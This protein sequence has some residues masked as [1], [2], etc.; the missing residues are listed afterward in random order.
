MN[1][2]LLDTDLLI[3]YLR[4]HAQ[5][6]EYLEKLENPLAVSAITIA[7]LY[8]GVRQNE[9]APLEK[10]LQLFEIIP[11]NAQ[12]AQLGGSF[13][14]DYGKSHGTGLV[15]A[16]IAATAV[17]QHL[18]LVTLNLRHYPMLNNICAPYNKKI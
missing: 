2:L 14:R 8:V 6:T 15:D 13:R 10:F 1:P 12:I 9:Q 3:D 11:L 17:I 7:E 16:L 18:Q 4:G 5:A